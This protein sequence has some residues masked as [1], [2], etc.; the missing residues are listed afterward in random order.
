MTKINIY[1]LFDKDEALV[2][3]YSSIKAVH[4]DALK[5]CNQGLAP[6]TA[7]YGNNESQTPSITLLRNLFKG[8]MNTKVRYLSDTHRATILKTK[9]KE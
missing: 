2:G 8:E 7:N 3:V 5:V 4:R 1:C 6:V 9:L